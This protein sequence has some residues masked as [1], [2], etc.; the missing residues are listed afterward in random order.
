MVKEKKRIEREQI[1][2]GRKF[3]PI[4]VFVVDRKFRRFVLVETKGVADEGTVP[5]LIKIELKDFQR[6]IGKL[7]R[8]IAWFKDRVESLKAELGLSP[9]E[10]YAVEGV[11]VISSPRLWMYA[12][13]EPLPVVDEY[14]FFRILN[15][16]GRFE[17]EPVP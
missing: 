17:T 1:P 8:Q 14:E 13:P 6:A 4:D 10:D 2:Q 15:K 12:Q 5:K 11:I 7:E 3:G 16:G 9:D